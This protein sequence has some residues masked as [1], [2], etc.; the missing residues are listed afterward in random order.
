MKILLI[1][2]PAHFHVY[3]LEQ[4]ETDKN[5]HLELDSR[6]STDVNGIAECL[7]LQTDQRMELE[8]I[9]RVLEQKISSRTLFTLN[10]L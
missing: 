4:K 1:G 7:G 6:F 10:S 3:K 9:I 2:D 8:D 5:L